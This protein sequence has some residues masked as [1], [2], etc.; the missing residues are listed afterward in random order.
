MNRYIIEFH[1]RGTTED[2]RN[3]S[4]S[5]TTAKSAKNKFMRTHKNW[6]VDSVKF[7]FTE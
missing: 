7:Y 2:L 4:V 6:T 1:K 5:A 3:T